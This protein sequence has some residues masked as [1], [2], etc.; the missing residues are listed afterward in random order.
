MVREHI[1]KTWGRVLELGKSM[2]ESYEKTPPEQRKAMRRIG[3]LSSSEESISMEEVERIYS[4]PLQTVMIPRINV[5][6]S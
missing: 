5:E 2:R 6:A 4:K 1:S 3:S